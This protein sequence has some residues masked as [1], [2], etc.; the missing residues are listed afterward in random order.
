MSCAAHA[1]EGWHPWLACIKNVFLGPVYTGS[2]KFLHG[3]KLARFHLAFTIFE[4]LSVKV[5][6]LKKSSS[7]TCTISR[8]NISPVP[9]VPCK[10]KV[11]PCKFLSVQKFVRTRVNGALEKP[12]VHSST[13]CRFFLSSMQSKLLQ[14]RRLKKWA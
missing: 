14:V 11:E 10:R 2:D 9:P 7:R 8:S 4:R 5:W 1:C 6:D 3:Q 12:R 13:V